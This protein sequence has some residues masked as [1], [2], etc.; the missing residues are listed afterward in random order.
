MY[1][2]NNNNNNRTKEPILSQDC[3]SV[4]PKT[5]QNHN[6]LIVLRGIEMEDWHK[7]G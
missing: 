2:N 3:I 1:N 6:F 4:S 5:S 7:M